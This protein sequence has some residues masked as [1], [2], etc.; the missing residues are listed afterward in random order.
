MTDRPLDR[1]GVPPPVPCGWGALLLAVALAGWGAAPL[2]RGG[3]PDLAALR[4]PAREAPGAAGAGGSTVRPRR[5]PKNLPAAR[6][7]LNRAAPADLAALPGIGP[8][9][10]AR[11]VEHR[12]AVGPFPR[13]EALRGVP[14]IGPKRY[15]R[16]APHILVGERERP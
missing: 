10:A 7:D 11:I 8:A 14:G 9:L 13:V 15:E 6:L 5:P 16:I 2:L 1:T 12:Q 4:P 3:G